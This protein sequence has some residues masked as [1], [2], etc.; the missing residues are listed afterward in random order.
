[1]SYINDFKKSIVDASKLVQD[2]INQ[3]PIDKDEA[4]LKA[5]LDT[6]VDDAAQLVKD[7][8]QVYSDLSKVKKDIQS[9]NIS[10]AKTDL[11]AVSK[12]LDKVYQEMVGKS[13]TLIDDFEKAIK[14]AVDIASNCAKIEK[15][16]KSKD[17]KDVV[18][19][20]GNI[21]Q[22]AEDLVGNLPMNASEKDRVDQVVKVVSKVLEETDEI[23]DDLFKGRADID[24]LE[25]NVKAVIGDIKSGASASQIQKDLQTLSTTIESS[26]QLVTDVVVKAKD[27]YNSIKHIFKH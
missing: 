17:L 12:D 25:K 15:D 5:D 9:G 26:L 1:M 2:I 19:L 10:A 20:I 13:T 6:L 24:S 11:D 4:N 27:I 14:D 3:K 21:D 7:G 23:A 22:E 18:A 8:D 16:I